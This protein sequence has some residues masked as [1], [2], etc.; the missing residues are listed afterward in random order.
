MTIDELKNEDNI[1]T[2]DNEKLVINEEVVKDVNMNNI[3]ESTYKVDEE[4][5]NSTFKNDSTNEDDDIEKELENILTSEDDTDDEYKKVVKDK[6]K[7]VLN[8]IDLSSY[9]IGVKPISMSNA[10]KSVTTDFTADW[11]LPNA[12]KIVTVREFTGSDLAK[13]NPRNYYK[14]RHE[15]FKSVYKLIFDHIVNKSDTLG[16][17]TWLKSFNYFDI[18]HLFFAIY[19]VSFSGSNTLPYTC[20]ANECKHTFMKDLDFE[21]MYKYVNDDAKN[22]CT[23]IMNGEVMEEDGTLPVEL[24]QVSDNYVFGFKCPSIYNIVF[25]TSLLDQNF[26]EKYSNMLSIAAHIENIYYIDSKNKT[27]QPIEIKNDPKSEVRSIKEKIVRMAKIINSLNS[28]QYN[29]VSTIV[30]KIEEDHKYIEYMIPATTCPKCGKDIEET[31]ISAESLLFTRHQL[32]ATAN[33]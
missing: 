18:D 29:F 3:T 24:V 14:S 22:L 12:K 16:F 5:S 27:L 9:S 1:T 11:V 7:P 28:D 20:T 2:S 25:E 6:I 26:T 13:L 33:S 32:I 23:K 4:N 15:A 21:S 30:D 19:K 8:V 31:S 10:L 17:E